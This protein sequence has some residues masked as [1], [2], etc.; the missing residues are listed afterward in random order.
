MSVKLHNHQ[1][2]RQIC[3][4]LLTSQ[5]TL[6]KNVHSLIKWE[7]T[8][9][10]RCITQTDIHKSIS[11]LKQMWCT[12]HSIYWESKASTCFKHYLLI[13]RMFCTNGIWYI[14]WLQCHSQLTLY[15]RNIPSAV[16]AA[17]N[18]WNM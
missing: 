5:P 4:Q 14:A 2:H 6:H 11:I 7:L 13:L 3:F 15:A 18:A 12:F 17:S 8:L 16:C 10:S 1:F 9:I